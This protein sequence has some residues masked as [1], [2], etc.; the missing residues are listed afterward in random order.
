MTTERIRIAV[1][2]PGR[3]GGGWAGA[4]AADLAAR[5]DAV[6]F[7]ASAEPSPAG[8]RAIL[9]FEAGLFGDKANAAILEHRER[10][11][12]EDQLNDFERVVDLTG[13]PLPPDLR[14]IGPSFDGKRSLETLTARLMR[15][16]PPLIQVRN[17]M[18]AVLAESLAALETPLEL[19]RMLESMRARCLA[20]LAASLDG[21]ALGGLMD[22][23]E[24][25][26]LKPSS[27]RPLRFGAERLGSA[28]AARTI[29][30]RTWPAFW[31]VAIRRSV[32]AEGPRGQP[33]IGWKLNDSGR[34]LADPCLHQRGSSLTLFA[35]SLDPGSPKG[36]IVAAEVEGD[37]RI[38]A[39]R[40][41]L[42]ETHHL[43]YP[44]VF[45][46]D[47]ETFMIPE[48]GAARRVDLYRCIQYPDRWTREATLVSGPKLV[49][50]TPLFYEGRWWLFCGGAE[51]GDSAHDQLFLYHAEALTGPWKPHAVR[52][53]ISDAR[54]ARPAGAIQK[55]DGKLYRPSQNNELRYGGGLV[56]S[57]IRELTPET[58]RETV[59]ERWSGADFGGF[60][61]VHTFSQAGGFQ[62]IDLLRLNAPQT[63]VLI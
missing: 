21:Q 27:T 2:V 40:T 17:G 44:F 34:F 54:G 37:G 10:L 11:A 50:A 63:K 38:C 30:R 19:G 59:I 57:E 16:E 24:R 46:D 6:C 25:G 14:Y 35:E 58:Y 5:Y 28:I 31:T 53:L 9:T 1:V 15:R 23:L 13:R 48:S 61:G 18:G 51:H 55:L 62:A 41:V 43:S 39:A 20:L 32:G 56:W 47:G 22:P 36:R 49:D 3:D 29:R 26:P 52:P 12:Q 33:G 8:A 7:G 42:E 4:L 60:D 45:D